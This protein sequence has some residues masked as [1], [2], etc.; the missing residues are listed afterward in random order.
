MH[1]SLSLHCYPST[2]SIGT[3]HRVTNQQGFNCA[4]PQQ[5]LLPEAEEARHRAT[6]CA[7]PQQILLPEV[8]EVRHLGHP[9]MSSY[10]S[11]EWV[12]L[13][14]R[15]NLHCRLPSILVHL[16]LSLRCYPS[17]SSIGSP[18]PPPLKD[19]LKELTRPTPSMAV[20]MLIVEC[21]R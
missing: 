4:D 8:E 13:F 18:R 2:S 19:S 15:S 3:Q 21:H 10:H 6:I 7:D 12:L 5:I 20:A 9:R 17:T 1:L 11:R 16:S 14:D